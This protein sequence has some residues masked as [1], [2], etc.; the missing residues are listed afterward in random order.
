[1]NTIRAGSTAVTAGSDVSSVVQSLPG[2]CAFWTQHLLCSGAHRHLL[3]CALERVFRHL[4]LCGDASR[5]SQQVGHHLTLLG[6]KYYV[7]RE[8]LEWSC[9]F[10]QRWSGS[11]VGIAG[12]AWEC[13]LRWAL[14]TAVNFLQAMVLLATD[15]ASLLGKSCEAVCALLLCR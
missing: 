7:V 10:R 1:M 4:F 13:T 11:P 5:G 2:Y 3:W 8:G 12:N 6:C 9:L 14:Q 15:V